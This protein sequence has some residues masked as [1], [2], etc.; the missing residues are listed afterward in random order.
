MT[1]E[2]AGWERHRIEALIASGVL[3]VN[4]GYRAKN[5]ELG[6][7][8]LPFARAANVNRGIRLDGADR[9][10][11]DRVER[12]GIKRSQPGDVVF[13]SKG[14]VGR[15]AFVQ[16]S[17][18]EFVYSPQ[19]CFW[20]VL[21]SRKIEPRFL[22]YWMH[23]R[24][25]ERQF[26]A[27]KGSTDM[28]DYISLRDQRSMSITFPPVDE[29]RRIADLLGSLDDKIESNHRLA[30]T[31]E[32]IATALYK[33]WF[34]EYVGHGNLVESEIGPIPQGWAVE[35]VGDVLRV[36]GGSTPSTKEPA[37]WDQGV[38]CWAT[39]KDLS[40]AEVPVLLDTARHVTDAGIDR[41]SSGLL[42]PRTVLMSSRA[43][44]GYT[45]ISLV[46]IAVNQGFIAVPPSDNIPSEYT[47]L[48]MR[49]NMDLIKAHAGG[50][51][52][53]EISKRAFRPLPMLVPS[54]DVLKDFRGATE[55]LVSRIA[56]C[57]RES[58]SL[59]K[60]RDLILPR[61]MSGQLR[62]PP[63]AGLVVGSS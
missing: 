24:E 63:E 26:D 7:E 28:A 57:V 52:F 18:P 30:S 6:E 23:G 1:S 8:G 17:T 43:P 34:V 49:A 56:A 39:P 53:A 45:A 48:W 12:A 21:D 58:A 40:G 22:H 59:A 25:C 29:Q 2:E 35:E 4:D 11:W 42:P 20:R 62:A 32:G 61:L 13:T 54:Q 38:H 44:V 46:P 60:T 9:L 47:L 31:L 15:F 55:P 36:V 50:T 37:F 14:T 10:R 5:A 19:L 27:A 33:A 3:V 16:D 51:T 41:I